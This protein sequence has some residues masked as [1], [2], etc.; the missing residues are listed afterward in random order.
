[1]NPGG[2]R[3]L[4]DTMSHAIPKAK[5]WRRLYAFVRPHQLKLFAVILLNLLAAVADVFS[6][7]LLI[8][9]LNALFGRAELVPTDSALGRI[10]NAT[11]GFLLQGAKMDAL[12]N[13]IL[14]ILAA[15][16]IKNVLIWLSGQIGSQLQEY[17]AR[18]LRQALYTHL[19]RLPLGWFTGNKVGQVIARMQNDT[20]IAKAVVTEL[21]TRSL[22]SAAQVVAALVA[23]FVTSWQLTLA[24]LFGAAP[25]ILLIQPV[26][27]KLR[28][29]HKRLGNEQGE[30]TSV[31]QETVSGIRLVKSY[32]AE[33]YEEARF[34]ERNNRF[35]QGFVKV[36]RLALLSQ[37]IT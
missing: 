21:V 22:W 9:F 13:V 30:M 26:L 23:M 33:A 15:V 8:P 16:A 31:I 29:G 12:R 28:K 37:P 20:T 1:M 6:F 35:A 34:G 27:R 25:A 32:G 17:V 5:A 24:S 4:Y 18:D 2:E 7:T 11:V 36:T 14:I 10:L 19:L 3:T